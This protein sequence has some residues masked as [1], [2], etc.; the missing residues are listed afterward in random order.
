MPYGWINAAPIRQVNANDVVGIATTLRTQI[1]AW[2]HGSQGWAQTRPYHAN[3]AGA[4]DLL[5][6]SRS[7]EPRNSTMSTNTVGWWLACC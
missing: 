1:A 7:W 5:R 2:G 4:D 6:P 3:I